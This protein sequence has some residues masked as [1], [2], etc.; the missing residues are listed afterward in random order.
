LISP[1]V[2]TKDQTLEGVD[3]PLSYMLFM[4]VCLAALERHHALAER[5][6]RIGDLSQL[7]LH[8][9]ILYLC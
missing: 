5:T 7:D 1:A 6:E 3:E 9:E 2:I 4:H 8:M